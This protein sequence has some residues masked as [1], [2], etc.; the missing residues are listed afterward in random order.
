MCHLRTC[1]N[2]RKSDAGP[3]LRFLQYWLGHESIQS[4]VIYAALVSQSR[5]KKAREFFMRLP[6]L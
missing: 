2:E 4:T 3:D 1:D 6:S 5:E